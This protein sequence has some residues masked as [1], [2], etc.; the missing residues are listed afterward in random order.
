M[1]KPDELEKIKIVA[2]NVPPTK[3]ELKQLRGIRTRGVL[4]HRRE[5]E[6]AL[7]ALKVC[8]G[9]QTEA[10]RKLNIAMSTFHRWIRLANNGFCKEW[11]E[12]RSWTKE[13][14][15]AKFKELQNQL[16][17]ELTHPYWQLHSKIGNSYYR[18]WPSWNAF[19]SEALGISLGKFGKFGRGQMSKEDANNLLRKYEAH[20]CSII[21]LSLSI[22]QHPKTLGQKIAI[23]K[24]MTKWIK[25]VKP[26][27]KEDEG[28]NRELADSLFNKIKKAV[29]AGKVKLVVTSAQN[30]TPIHEQFYQSLLSYC[31]HNK[32]ILVVIPYRYKNPTSVFGEAM[33][34]EDWWA[35]QLH[36]HILDKRI[37][38]NENLVIL[39]DIKTQPTAVT[40]LQGFETISHASSAIIGHPKIE[41][42][43][44]ATPQNKLPKILT[45]TGS[46]TKQNYTY[47]RAGKKGEHHHTFGA[48]IV[49]VEGKIFHMR[50]L[51]ALDD[52]SF[53]DLDKE[54]K[55]KTIRKI[56][57]AAGLVMGDTHVEVIDE[58]VVSATFGPGGIV[59]ML[60]PEVL[61]WHDV[62]DFYAGNHWHKG[63]VFI[64][65]AKH[66]S[67]RNNVKKWLFDTFDF[68][69]KHSQSDIVNVFPYS[70]HPNNHFLRWIEETNPKEDPENAVFWAETFHAVLAS[71]KWTKS[72]VR[73]A[74]PFAYWGR[75]LLPSDNNI[76]LGPQQGYMI[77]DIEVGYHGDNGPGGSRGSRLQFAKIG[78]KVVIGHAHVPGIR[79]GAYQVGTS[80]L[81]DLEYVRGPSAWL[82]THCVMYQN[83]KRSLINIIDGAWHLQNDRKTPKHTGKLKPRDVKWICSECAIKNG[84]KTI[85]DHLAT[86]HKNKCRV[87]RKEKMVT[88]PR[89]FDWR[90][91]SNE[92]S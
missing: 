1:S 26:L 78:T 9:N 17:E 75:K 23:A 63:K 31:E 64:N 14:M 4:P 28:I 13:K 68:I 10:A 61:V 37:N 55:G 70:N 34:K 44:I 88:E 57:R 16:D 43:T 80:S 49:E 38:V 83:G 60:Q 36:S 19:R 35:E 5:L 76:F 25:P 52:G 73:H 27:P 89:D 22:Q 79:D 18:F 7:W 46:V 65:F 67:K 85:T 41:L 8:K 81:L 2:T 77:K 45:T 30:A 66:H 24:L 29:K 72:G 74:D 59:D 90:N 32:A 62:H 51:N 54:Y 48:C 69:D 82:H 11:Q 15:I 21:A 3:G 91:A 56:K 50:Q 53:M 47:S 87:C 84:A 86:Y 12:A 40:P 42:T 6:I 92:Q 20:N 58:N 39:A 71:T 33:K